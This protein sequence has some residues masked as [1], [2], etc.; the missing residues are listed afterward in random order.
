MNEFIQENGE[1]LEELLQELGKDKE[2]KKSFIL[3]YYHDFLQEWLGDMREVGG[4]NVKEVDPDNEVWEELEDV[5]AM[6]NEW[7]DIVYTM[8]Y[9]DALELILKKLTD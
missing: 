6:G 8:G 3:S 2:E 9:I 5:S 1:K 7:E 4:E